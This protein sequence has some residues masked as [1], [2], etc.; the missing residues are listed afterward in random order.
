MILTPIEV[1]PLVSVIMIFL[2]EERFIGEA[3]DSVFAQTYPKWELILVDDGSSD[4]SSEIARS[5]AARHPGQVRYIDHPGHNNLGMSA[6]RNAGLAAA[7]GGFLTFL[8]ADDVYLPQKLE[9]QV[10]M[11]RRHPRAGL[12]YAATQYWHSWDATA[13]RSDWTWSKFGTPPDL[14]VE[15]PN[16][17]P[18]YL[19]DGGTLPCM[20]GLMVRRKAVE[21]IGGW[22]NSFRGLFEDQVLLAKLALAVPAVPMSACLDRYRQHDHSVSA[23]AGRVKTQDARK[24]FLAWLEGYLHQMG[25]HDAS[26]EKALAA[27]RPSAPRRWLPPGARRVARAVRRWRNGQWPPPGWVSFGSLRRTSPLS[28]SWGQDRG[29]ALDRY[30]V[31]GFLEQYRGD[32]K[33]RVLEIGDRSYTEKFGGPAVGVSDVLHVSEGNPV[34]TIVAD[35]TDAPQ[36]PD[37]TFDC[38]ILT[39]TLQLIFDVPAAL[40][41]VHRILKPGGVLL[42][43]FPGITHTGDADWSEHWCWSFTRRSARQLFTPVF[44]EGNIALASHGNVLAATAFLYGL[45]DRELT[46]RELDVHDPTYDMVITVRAT[47]GADPA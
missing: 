15:P 47:R 41:T 31:E 12:V 23:V 8:D 36:I 5:I 14:L 26:I 16:L 44:G 46:T 35:L 20:G 4:R 18:V 3:I 19:S 9:A 7:R 40:R 34:A 42:A 10:A 17:L 27:S 29:R 2:N 45:A 25:V 43:T 39:Q 11:F 30:Y 21:A 38:I 1:Q 6:S 24:T 13:G 32:I 33:G 22:E 37:Q 28:R